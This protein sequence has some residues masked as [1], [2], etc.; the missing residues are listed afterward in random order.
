[1]TNAHTIHLFLQV[2][3]RVRVQLARTSPAPDTLATIDAE[4]AHLLAAR[5]LF[6]RWVDRQRDE[7]HPT[8]TPAQFLRAWGDSTSRIIALLKA[9][10][11][12]A[13]ETASDALLDAV[14]AELEAELTET[15]THEQ[16]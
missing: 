4:L 1:M 9:R 11:D 8:I 2:I 5:E 7:P 14:Y 10:K 13:G 3:D 15:L 16:P 12:L 6:M